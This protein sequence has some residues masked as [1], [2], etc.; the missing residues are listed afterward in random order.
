MRQDVQSMIDKPGIYICGDS[1]RPRVRVVILSQDGKLIGMRQDVIVDP[2]V[3]VDTLTI[4]GP[5]HNE[6]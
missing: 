6:R 4:S 5:F 2:E 1:E 3:V